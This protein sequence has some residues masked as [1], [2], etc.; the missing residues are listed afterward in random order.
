VSEDYAEVRKKY[1]KKAGIDHLVDFRIVNAKESLTKLLEDTDQYRKHSVDLCFI[2]ADKSSYD[3]YHK[4]CLCLT[5]PSGLIVVDNT[6][7][8]GRVIVPKEVY[9][10]IRESAKTDDF[11]N[12]RDVALA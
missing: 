11:I 6:F 10:S 1:W 5:K 3:D 8:S 12:S 9:E 4:K 7:W 2:D